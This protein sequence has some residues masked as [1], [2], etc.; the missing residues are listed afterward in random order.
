MR[1]IIKT[2]I[3]GIIII[4]VIYGAY[5]LFLF[6]FAFLHKNVKEFVLPLQ[7]KYDSWEEVFKK[8]KDIQ[9]I[10]V[11]SGYAVAEPNARP[12]LNLESLPQSYDINKEEIS[13][14]YSYFIK[15]PEKGDLLI[16][17]GLDKSFNAGHPY[18][19]L[20]LMLRMYQKKTKTFYKQSENENLGRWLDKYKINPVMVLMTHLHPDHLCGLLEVNDP[21]DIVFGKKEN[22]FF[23][24]AIAG[25]Y[26]G[27]KKLFAVDFEKSINLPPFGRVVDLFGDGSVWAIS[28]PGHTIDHISYFVNIKGSP[29]LLVGDL[30]MSRNYF[31]DNIKINSDSG[32]KGMEQLEKS[33]K[34]F[35]EFKDNYP[36]VKIYFTHSDENY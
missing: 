13:P 8:G 1:L 30:T 28:S 3:V 9:I 18:G 7:V 33:L 15:H 14:I 17:A 20:H 23:Y 22:G 36:E 5:F 21:A 6:R 27:R 35:K 31:F 32:K 16:D 29:A 2:G 25:K 19:S 11:K 26:F 24:L 10:A 4:A 34:E 12:Y